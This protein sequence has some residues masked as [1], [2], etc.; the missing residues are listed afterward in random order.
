VANPSEA[1]IVASTDLDPRFCGG[2]DER[3]FSITRS[4]LCV[5]IILA[6]QIVRAT[7]VL[8]KVTGYLDDDEVVLLKEIP[9]VVADHL[10]KP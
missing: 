2:T 6:G 10:S 5:P 7:E 3:T 9:R 1:L 4:N 8:N